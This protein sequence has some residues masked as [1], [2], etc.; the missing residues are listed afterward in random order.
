M[1]TTVEPPAV[2]PSVAPPKMFTQYAL[3]HKSADSPL[4]STPACRN[5]KT[6]GSH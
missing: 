1:Y 2:D 5:R 6:V 3:S 4:K